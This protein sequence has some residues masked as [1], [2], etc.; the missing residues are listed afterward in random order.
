MIQS[1]T[2]QNPKKSDTPPQVV[3]TIAG[4]DPSSGAGITADLKTFAAHHLYGICCPTALTVQSTRGVGRAVPVDAGLVTETLNCLAEDTPLAGV[5][6]GMLSNAV[7]AAAVSDFLSTTGALLSAIVLDPVLRSSSGVALLEDEGTL[8]IRERM[9]GQVGWI[10][11][12]VDE[13]AELL[14][15]PVAGADGIPP[16]AARLQQLAA[17]LGNMHLRIVVTGGHLD[18]PDDYFLDCLE[19]LLDGSLERSKAA[20]HPGVWLR[21]ERIETS[22]THGTGC[23][24]SSALLCQLV[25]GLRPAEAVAAAKNWVTGALRHAYPIGSGR[26]PMN[27]FFEQW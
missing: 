19:G 1:E 9:L 5:K 22:S 10:T 14:D 16:Q 18:Q 2:P 15:E 8:I 25:H 26:G 27:H 21:G 11:P 13:L 20:E 23:A 12:N 17:R 24:F 3:L 7:V 6:I 4:L